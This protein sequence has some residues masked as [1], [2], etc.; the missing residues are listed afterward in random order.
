MLT[1]RA[2]AGLRH[3]ARD[4]LADQERALEVDAQHGVEV[5][6]GD[7]QEVGRLEDAGVVHQHVDAAVALHRGGDQRVDLR[8]VA[9]VAGDEGA[10]QFGRQCLAAAVSMSAITGM[11][12]SRAK[13][14][15]QASPMP[16]E[17]PVTMHT[18]PCRP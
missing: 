15:A 3:L 10:A 1:M 9:D 13:R 6:F 11:A 5:G 14:R 17:P 12:P 7:G 2:L 16:C 18:R 4:G 8:L